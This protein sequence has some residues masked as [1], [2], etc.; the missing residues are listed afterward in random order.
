MAYAK[1]PKPTLLGYFF[2]VPLGCTLT[3]RFF[4][5]RV[6]RPIAASCLAF[7]LRVISLHCDSY[8]CATALTFCGYFYIRHK[9]SPPFCVGLNLPHCQFPLHLLQTAGPQ[10][11]IVNQIFQV[12]CAIPCSGEDLQILMWDTKSLS[13]VQN[14]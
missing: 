9:L 2:A 10:F 6:P 4:L 3:A 8:S 1:R 13:H 5:A 7:T 11:L 14:K 12:K